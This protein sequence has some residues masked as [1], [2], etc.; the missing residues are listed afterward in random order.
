M[1]TTKRLDLAYRPSLFSEVL[2]QEQ[3]VRVLQALIRRNKLRRNLLLCGDRGSGKTSLARIY[4]KALNCLSNAEDGSPCGACTNCLDGGGLFEYDTAG[5]GGDVASVDAFLYRAE[6]EDRHCDVRVLFFDEAHA[7]EQNAADILLKRIE[8]TGSDFL[9]CFATTAPGALRDALVSRLM[10]LQVRALPHH[11][12]V[13]LLQNVADKEGL[14]YDVRALELL[15]AV[16]RNYPRDLL[17][18][19]EQLAFN[20]GRLAVSDVKEAFGVDQTDILYDYACALV[21]GDSSR[22]GAILSAWNED[23]LSKVE[24]IRN[25]FISLYYNNVLNRQVIV[26]PVIHSAVA[27]HGSIVESF[28]ERMKALDDRQWK[29]YWAGLLQFWADHR[30]ADEASALLTI[31]LFERQVQQFRSPAPVHDGVADGTIARVIDEEEH[32]SVG[33]STSEPSVI[34]SQSEFLTTIEVREIVNRSSFFVQQ[35]GLLFNCAMSIEPHAE[36]EEAAVL[37]IRSFCKE[38][39]EA[40]RR[41]HEASADAA[42]VLIER[43][44]AQGV[45]GLIVG[46][47]AVLENS[48][49]GNWLRQ[50]FA[51]AEMASGSE[52]AS[53]DIQL[54]SG[55]EKSRLKLHWKSVL[56]LCA[57]VHEPGV[58]AASGLIRNGILDDLGINKKE[59]REPRPIKPPRLAFY[60]ALQTEILARDQGLRMDFLSAYDDRAFDWVR[61]GWELDEHR[62]RRTEAES[63]ELKMQSIRE[64]YRASVE[65][66]EAEEGQLQRWPTDP[67]RRLRSWTNTWWS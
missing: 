7:L 60:G 34:E 26:D 28:R 52:G 56:K 31:A 25:L 53:I 55:N 2:G 11:T 47:F 40:A 17:I 19:L 10:V 61:N 5:K 58:S 44:Q 65:R 39:F 16:K 63:R 18:G 30:P 59:R 29:A 51:A 23:P 27:D 14:D 62:D 64:R 54:A 42:I 1:R 46:R 9:Y 8:E 12:S 45:Y 35:H 66:K 21:E 15:A 67:K 50:Q 4:A 20:G 57:S 38:L 36:T 43:G 6:R 24:W 3:A 49:G 48:S 22:Q 13:S 32:F 41:S 37:W 33:A